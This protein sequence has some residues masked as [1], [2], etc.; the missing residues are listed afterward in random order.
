VTGSANTTVT[1]KVNGIA[2]GNPLFG[3]IDSTGLYH[4]PTAPTAAPILVSAVSQA[5][6][7]KSDAGQ[8]TVTFTDASLVGDYVFFAAVGDTNPLQPA[9]P[10][11]AF[12]AGTF[13]ADGAGNL[14][15]GVEDTNSR[16]AGPVNNIAFTGTYTV[17]PDGR[18]SASITAGVTT[19]PFKFV[20]ISSD[21]AQLIEFDG[22]HAASGVVLRQDP[23]A[24]AN[25]TGT[26]V[27]S[28]LG[29]NAGSPFGAIG[30]LRA[31]GAG[32]LSGS[33]IE[34]DGG[35]RNTFT[36]TGT[37]VVG[38]G[39]RGTATITNVLNVSR[40]F[41]FYI[42]NAGIIQLVS[43]D[44][45]AL[46]RA[47]GTGFLQTG[48]GA[49]A[50]SAFFIDGMSVAGGSVSAAGR[51]DT[52]GAGT[53]TGGIFDSFGA[54][55]ITGSPLGTYSFASAGSGQISV[56]NPGS[57]FD[58][59][60]FSSTEAVVLTKPTIPAN[61]SVVATGLIAAEQGGPFTAAQFSGNY[62]FDAALDT[63]QAGAG[64]IFA[65]GAGAFTGNEDLADTLLFPDLALTA[66]WSFAAGRGAGTVN[67]TGAL[68]SSSPIVFYPVSANEVIFSSNGAMGLAEKQC[69][70][71]H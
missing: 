39:G 11:F 46:P 44:T 35:S 69:S 14:S 62:A 59:W 63:G 31:D 33:D 24:V 60:F 9:Q 17:N 10:G 8:V 28:M 20:L 51:F 40:H 27:F 56:L 6:T 21:R 3:T 54:T 23:A 29:D 26:F 45:A 13:H 64:Q 30:A 52:N 5:D 12:A 47:A 38:T 1:W 36:L 4:S 19:T 50:S 58:F 15:S 16:D 2:G 71:C 25:V 32:N 49:M 55:H 22:V 61:Q 57:A 70:D 68:V 34:N 41:I 48:I 37:Y 7:T 65:D 53:I 43:S 67:T 42:V 66:T 18:G